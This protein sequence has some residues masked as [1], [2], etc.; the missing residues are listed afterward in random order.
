MEPA[1]AA[2]LREKAAHFRQL[3]HE[4]ADRHTALALGKKADELEAQA[5]ALESTHPDNA[6][7]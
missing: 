5:A 4:I 1:D 6:P 7:G 2:A 3:A